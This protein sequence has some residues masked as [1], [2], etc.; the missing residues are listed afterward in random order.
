MGKFYEM[1][2]SVEALLC[3]DDQLLFGSGSVTLND[4]I[5]REV[6]GMQEENQEEEEEEI[7]MTK[8]PGKR[9]VPHYT[10]MHGDTNISSLFSYH[11][12]DDWDPKLCPYQQQG[13]NVLFFTF[14]NPETMTDV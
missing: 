3:Q 8:C 6:L 4:D 12:D 5:P 13:A 11:T 14:I 1:L 9:D 7:W 2:A 10:I